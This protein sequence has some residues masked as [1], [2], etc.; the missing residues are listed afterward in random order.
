MG[1]TTNT[2]KEIKKNKIRQKIQNANT[3]DLVVIPA[4]PIESV[5]SSSSIHRVAAYCR[6]STDEETQTTSFELQKSTYTE[7]I[8]QHP[9]WELAGIYADEGISGT[10]FNHRDGMKQMIEDCKAGKIDMIITKSIARF[11]RNIVDCLDTIEMLKSLPHPVG[12][13][14]ETEHLYTLD[15]SGRM[16]LAILST[17]AEEESHSKSLIMNWSVD[18]RFSKGLFLT[19]P[20]Y[21]YDQDPETDKLVINPEEAKVVRL[22][23]GLY[24]SGFSFTSIADTLT[25]LGVKTYTGKDTWNPGT[26][27]GILSNERHY[28]AVLAHKTYTPSFLNHK[29]KKNDGQRRKYFRE[30]DHEPIVSKT[31]FE[32]AAKKMEIAHAYKQNSPMPSLSVVDEGILTG[33][34]PVN[35]KWQGFTDEDFLAAT[36]S[37]YEPAEQENGHDAFTLDDYQVVSASLFTD[38]QQPKMTIRDSKVKFNTACLKKFENVEYVEILL[39]SVEKCIAIRPSSKENPNAIRWGRLKD[40]KWLCSEHS[41]LGLINPV[42]ALMGWDR[43]NKYV[44]RGQFLQQD[45]GKLLI[46]DLSD[47]D[48]QTTEPEEEDTGES[49][50]GEPAVFGDTIYFEHRKYSGNWDVLRPAAFYKYCSDITEDEMK[51]VRATTEELLEELREA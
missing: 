22:C 35:R 47:V 33:Y 44:I 39:N 8:T 26:I 29:A 15:D 43:E 17:V 2:Q 1:R 14:F 40:S 37:V 48:C 50:F 46:F 28:G 24:L 27:Q 41:A 6:V 18:N 10:S 31:I 11:A 36:E 3:E 13:Q 21:G 7:M 25:G 9:G 5:E 32:A 20:L 38:M 49:D 16:I 23:F 42:V 45:D 19:P 51:K 4:K 30:A 12:V 34:V